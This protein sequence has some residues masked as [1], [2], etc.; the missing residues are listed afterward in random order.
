M[1]QMFYFHLVVWSLIDC[2]VLPFLVEQAA[3]V[4][5]KVV[6]ESDFACISGSYDNQY[7]KQEHLCVG[8][9]GSREEEG[10]VHDESHQGC[11]GCECT[12]NK[13]ETH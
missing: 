10:C 13:S 12:E 5:H 6:V 2:L 4:R 9:Y 7:F 3:Q 8:A 11:E 1:G